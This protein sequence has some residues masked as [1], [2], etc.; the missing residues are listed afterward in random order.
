MANYFDQFYDQKDGEGEQPSPKGNYF[1]QF[2][3]KEEG[4]QEPKPSTEGYTPNY[5]DS[6]TGAGVVGTSMN[7]PHIA[8]VAKMVRG[9][10]TGAKGAK[11]VLSKVSKLPLLNLGFAA[12]D[13]LGELTGGYQFQAPIANT[14]GGLSN[15]VTGNKFYEGSLH[16]YFSTNQHEDGDA[17]GETQRSKHLGNRLLGMG[18]ASLNT[19]TGGG[20]DVVRHAFDNRG[21][22]Q[23]D[24]ETGRQSDPFY[25]GHLGKWLA[26]K[27]LFPNNSQ[28]DPRFNNQQNLP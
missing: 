10:A 5:D 1:D 9:A 19:L 26:E 21:F 3:N 6:L 18:D 23:Y 17:F 20:L 27:T 16:D 14:L 4:N 2:Y 15:L 8:G 22:D 11:Q 28:A 12:D 13:A 7:I 25:T 24:A